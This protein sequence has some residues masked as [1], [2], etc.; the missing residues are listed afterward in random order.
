ML[1]SLRRKFVAIIMTL[2]GIVLISVLGGSYVSSWQAQRE[3]VYEALERNLVGSVYDFPRMGTHMMGDRE[4]QGRANVLI[5]AIDLD[6]EG[7]VLATNNAP[8]I[9]DSSALADLLGS[10]LKSDADTMWNESN[11]VAWMRQQ[12]S[13]GSWRVVI[14][15]T[16]AVDVS[17]S[18]LAARDVAIIVLAMAVLLVI[19]IFL[20][21]WVLKPVEA[22][23]DQQ[24]QFIAD[25]SHELKT[26]LAVIIANTQIL[27]ADK[28]IPSESMRWIQ[29]TADESAHMKSLVEELLEL[30]RTDETTA[31]AKDVMRSESV[32]FSAMVENAALE[33]DAIAFERGSLI[34]QDIDQDVCV[35]GDPEWLARL[36]K[37]LIDNACKYSAPGSPVRVELHKEPKR[38]ALSVNNHGNVIDPADLPHVFDRFY[39]T[40][41]ARS[42]DAHTGGF[43]LGLA[44]AKGICTSH[45]GT[46]SATSDE[47]TGTTFTAT[48]PTQS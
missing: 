16:S 15:D 29:S 32:D 44:I 23:W 6:S 20:S 48:L 26:P 30:A 31:G 28:G 5:L 19:S 12:R 17:L 43:G 35:Q 34:E 47:A 46:I 24:R 36:C 38:C 33:F 3:L 21:T 11:H 41:K 42:R 18:T 9:V 39:R 10:I 7:M 40:D 22:A 14:A 37:I 1:K 4:D 27:E 25:A 2:V 8:I 13:S 45:G